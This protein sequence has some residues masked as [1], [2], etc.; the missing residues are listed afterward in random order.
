M[1]G[2]CSNASPRDARGYRVEAAL[3]ALCQKTGARVACFVL[4]GLFYRPKERKYPNPVLGF[5]AKVAMLL[6][7]VWA[8]VSSRLRD[9]LAG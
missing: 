3:N 9:A 6:V 2:S 8:Y 5:A 1:D 4:E 7:A